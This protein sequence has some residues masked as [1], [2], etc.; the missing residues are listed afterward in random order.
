MSLTSK[1]P[2][3]TLPTI[4]PINKTTSVRLSYLTRQQKNDRKT[5]KNSRKF[6]FCSF[7][8]F[9]LFEE[10]KIN[11]WMVHKGMSDLKDMAILTFFT[12]ARYL[13][14]CFWVFTFQKGK[15]S[16]DSCS[17]M[18]MF[19]LEEKGNSNFM[20]KLLLSGKSI[21]K[22]R[23]SFKKTWKSMREIVFKRSSERFCWVFRYS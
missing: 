4:K 16:F 6:I 19:E 18:E 12:L 10:E 20:Q 7:C 8:F 17:F 15:I 23:K 14:Y 13:F 11:I 2:K 9:Y 22:N 5:E 3:R 21:V 1:S